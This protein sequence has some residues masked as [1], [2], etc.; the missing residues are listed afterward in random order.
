M[1]SRPIHQHHLIASTEF[2]LLNWT[3]ID[4]D[5]DCSSAID[6]HNSSLKMENTLIFYWFDL[7]CVLLLWAF[8]LITHE[9]SI[10]VPGQNDKQK[11]T[12]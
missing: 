6:R 11:A 7:I 4:F 12:N 8:N 1:F 5:F 9:R 3:T 2:I 10:Y